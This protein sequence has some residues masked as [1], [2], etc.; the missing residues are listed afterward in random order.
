MGDLRSWIE[1]VGV[2]ELSDA[3]LAMYLGATR[4]AVS[5]ARGG[6]AVRPSSVL[7][8]VWGRYGSE[9]EVMDTA[10]I[11]ERVAAIRSGEGA[12]LYEAL[13]A[14][15]AG[16]DAGV[17]AEGDAEGAGVGVGEAGAVDAVDA[18]V[19][20]A[21]DGAA[22]SAGDA[23]VDVAGVSAADAVV[24]SGAV[25]DVV[26]DDVVGDGTDAGE[27][28]DGSGVLDAVLVSDSDDVSGAVVG[29]GV[30][31]A[32]VEAGV[33]GGDV[34]N[35]NS[36]VV[37]DAGLVADAGMDVGVGEA[38]DGDLVG[39]FLVTDGRLG[40][41]A[42]AGD[43]VDAGAV[44]DGESPVGAGAGA[45]ADAGGSGDAAD[46]GES[47]GASAGVD[48][49][50]ARDAAAAAVG[51][52]DVVAGDSSAAG[53]GGV[54]GGVAAVVGSVRQVSGVRRVGGVARVV[55]KSADASADSESADVVD[56]ALLAARERI[57][58]SG[59]DAGL[60][61]GLREELRYWTTLEER[62]AA[63]A[64]WSALEGGGG[65]KQLQRLRE[66]VSESEMKEEIAAYSAGSVLLS[67][68]E[69]DLEDARRCALRKLDD[70][71]PSDGES[72]P[73][74][75]G[76]AVLL[77][78]F[79]VESSYADAGAREVAFAEKGRR[80]GNGAGSL[81][82]LEL[83]YGISAGDRMRRY[84]CASHS[85][86][87]NRI[88]FYR[89]SDWL[90]AEPYPDSDWFFGSEG[91][92]R[93][94]GVW[95]PSLA[96]LAA[97]Y[98]RIQG[99]RDA[100]AGSDCEGSAFWLELE[101]R[102][103]ECQYILLDPDYWMTF[104]FHGVGRRIGGST[105][106]FERHDLRAR[107]VELDGRL[108]GM[109]RGWRRGARWLKGHSVRGGVS[110]IADGDVVGERAWEVDAIGWR[111]RDRRRWYASGVGCL[112]AN[113]GDYLEMLPDAMAYDWGGVA[114]AAREVPGEREREFEYSRWRI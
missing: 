35:G 63:R 19:G 38:A 23:V 101:L 41:D 14:A 50:V 55:V 81:S 74:L 47:V 113:A 59:T 75:E 67:V 16:A 84:A 88:G 72:L 28:A 49:G 87:P 26:S 7:G 112:S 22:V 6:R 111:N 9:L 69:L 82:A 100:Y 103:L 53:V 62:D 89:L 46:I 34:G 86:R 1:R 70:W 42:G 65:D 13:L 57:A 77:F 90:P 91:N 54:T 97:Y 12:S 33:S 8:Q 29:V 25:S 56:E 95:M 108:R 96:E 109:R 40:D 60:A 39:G 73:H 83:R 80:W 66:L 5:R 76:D 52:P 92:R 32:D 107:I 79:G 64:A 98:Y 71:H 114:R 4:A 18:G 61:L 94:S 30:G 21:D 104:H 43:G 102:H 36:D 110:A 2:G 45:D 10:G 27:V 20:S 105:R 85:E 44:A 99:M 68:P 31:A 17:A 11:L 37:A 93:P 58:K 3:R 24:E 106:S 48:A 78:Y 51:E 15:E